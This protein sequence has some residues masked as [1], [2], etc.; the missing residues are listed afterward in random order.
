MNSFT[1]LAI[2]PKPRALPVLDTPICWLTTLAE[3]EHDT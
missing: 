2:R 1:T 3:N